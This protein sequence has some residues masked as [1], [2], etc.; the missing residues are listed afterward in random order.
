MSY[1]G[2]IGTLQRLSSDGNIC[3]KVNPLVDYF[4]KEEEMLNT[5]E[6]SAT[7]K[8]LSD[9]TCFG[10]QLKAGDFLPKESPLRNEPGRIEALCR[11]RRLA[12]AAAEV[13]VDVRMV[14][15]AKTAPATST[16][17]TVVREKRKAAKR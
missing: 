16:T 17:A 3:I 5:Y 14:H 4:R 12:P 15:A 2:P 11:Q 9:M 7:Y 10:V 6:P 8:V 1:G 13:K